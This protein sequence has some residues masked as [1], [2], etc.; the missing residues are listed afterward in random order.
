[1]LACL[2]LVIS[3]LKSFVSSFFYFN[4][5]C[6]SCAALS[7]FLYAYKATTRTYQGINGFYNATLGN[8]DADLRIDSASERCY[9]DVAKFGIQFKLVSDKKNL[10]KKN[11]INFFF[12]ND[13]LDL[14]TGKWKM[15]TIR[16]NF[17][18]R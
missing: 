17:S 7:L 4:Y 14:V 13:V 12:E 8:T 6:Q 2:S 9:F 1:M 18:S 16:G 10:E 11:F 3:A 15:T 5:F